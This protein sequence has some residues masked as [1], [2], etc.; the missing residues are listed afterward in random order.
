MDLSMRTETFGQDDRSW[1]GSSHGADMAR[2][3]TLDV[4]LF[5][6][7]THY[8]DGWIR[9]GTPL[10]Q[11]TAS[12]LYGPYD[13]ALTNGQEVLA[14]FLL[15][16]LTVSTDPVSAKLIGALYEH[17]RVVTARLPIDASAGAADLPTV[18]FA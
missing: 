7:A 10:G 16:A 11:V 6:S 1:L 12:G 13:S 5:D 4:S 18:I 9:S 3:I 17:G 2:S 8:P 15:S 14:G